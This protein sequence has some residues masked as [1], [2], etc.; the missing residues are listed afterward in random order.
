MNP[1]PLTP[2]TN[3]KWIKNLNV[4]PD[5]IR[6]WEKN[7]GSVRFDTDLGNV[8]FFMDLSPHTSKTKTKQM[9]QHQI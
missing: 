8:F 2:Y 5:I 9:G 4:K 7:I 3:S 1:L 6:L